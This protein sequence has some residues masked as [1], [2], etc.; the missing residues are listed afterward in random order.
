MFKYVIAGVGV[1]CCGVVVCLVVFDVLFKKSKNS[2]QYVREF[3]I[4]IE[5][6]Q[7]CPLL[8]SQFAYLLRKLALNEINSFSCFPFSTNFT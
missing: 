6:S 3:S 1:F 2:D 4:V 5:K 8:I 7:G